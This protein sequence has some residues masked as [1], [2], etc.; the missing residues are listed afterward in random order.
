MAWQGGV[1]CGAV[2]REVGVQS[3]AAWGWCGVRYII[4]AGTMKCGTLIL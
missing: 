1:L 2:D 4:L 3:A